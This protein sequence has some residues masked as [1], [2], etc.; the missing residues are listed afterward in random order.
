MIV[1]LAFY[2]RT[3]PRPVDKSCAF[4]SATL[5]GLPHLLSYGGV[6]EKVWGSFSTGK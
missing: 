1:L 3:K 4:L 2:I 6:V 5:K